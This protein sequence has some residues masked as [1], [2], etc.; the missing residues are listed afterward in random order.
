[1]IT[2][3]LVMLSEACLQAKVKQKDL[4]KQYK[5]SPRLTLLLP[6]SVYLPVFL[7]A[8]LSIRE[9]CAR[10]ALFKAH[11]IQAAM[12]NSTATNVLPGM[13]E[14]DTTEKVAIASRLLHL[15]NER[16]TESMTLIESDPNLILPIAVGVALTLNIELSAS[17]RAAFAAT[18]N[19]PEVQRT[20]AASKSLSIPIELKMTQ[21]LEPPK[22]TLRRR[23]HSSRAENNQLPEKELA[24][25]TIAKSSNLITNALRVL[26]VGMIMIAVQAPVV[27]SFS[28]KGTKE[29][30]LN[31]RLLMCTGL[32]MVLIH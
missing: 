6:F 17:I 16:L 29:L 4:F 8:T 20:S 9:A 28:L 12:G 24:I 10:A 3:L 11:V 18:K 27:G 21:S 5:C 19:Q 7:C 1:M 22:G 15:A 31:T 13:E 30:N 2:R 32:R 25:S 23:F 14:I 26:S